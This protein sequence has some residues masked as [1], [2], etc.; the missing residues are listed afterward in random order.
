VSATPAEG[1]S[2]AAPVA[3]LPLQRPVRALGE[4][5][6]AQLETHPRV[7]RAGNGGPQ[8]AAQTQEP[9][10]YSE[11]EA[12]EQCGLSWPSRE[13]LPRN[14]PR[15]EPVSA[16]KVAAGPRMR[17]IFEQLLL[18]LG[19]RRTADLAHE[20]GGGGSLGPLLFFSRAPRAELD[21]AAGGVAL[22]PLQI[23]RCRKVDHLRLRRQQQ[24]QPNAHRPTEP[25]TVLKRPTRNQPGSLVPSSLRLDAQRPA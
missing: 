11:R 6:S 23:K 5:N 8:P 25:R 10:P 12:I 15:P 1:N 13:K 7:L 19:S 16:A 4:L 20:T 9:A 3:R 17:S 24:Q 14:T 2:G 22:C 21:P 18:R